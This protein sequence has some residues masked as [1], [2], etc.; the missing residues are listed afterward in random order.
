MGQDDWAYVLCLLQ[1][2][3]KCAAHGGALSGLAAAALDE[4][5]T[6]QT[7]PAAPAPEAQ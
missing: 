6:I 3:E 7:P 4:L 1:V 5:K 2:V